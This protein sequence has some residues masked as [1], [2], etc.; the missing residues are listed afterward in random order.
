[1]Q[2]KTAKPKIVNIPAVVGK[3][4]AKWWH[5]KGRYRVVKGSRA[6]KKS[7]TASMWLVCYISATPGANALVVR[8]VASTLRDSVYAQIR[9]AIHN[10]ELDAYWQ[11]NVSPLEMTYTPT[12]QKILF[13]GCDDALKLS[14][15]TVP[16]GDLCHVLIEEAYEL[17]EEEFNLID[18][19]IRGELSSPSLYKQ[20][21]CIFNPWLATSWLKRRFFDREGD[22]DILAITT[23]YQCN[24]WLDEADR[25][26]F[27]RMAVESPQRFRV[28]GLGEWGVVG[29]SV[30]DSELLMARLEHIG[31]PVARGMFE[32]EA[33]GH[34]MDD[35][36]WREDRYGF[37]KIYERPRPGRPYVIGGD[38]AGA[39]SDSFV[40]QVIDNVTGCQVAM[41]RQ[42]FDE[43]L[44]AKQ[45]YCLG[46]M[47]N[48]ALVSIENNFST[49]PV[50]TLANL[51]YHNLWVRER[52]DTYTGKM[53]K[54]YGWLTTAG[55][56]NRIVGQLIEVVRETPE[57][58]ADRTTIEEMLTFVRGED[59]KPQA[60]E[61]AH[62]DTVMALCIAFASRDQQSYVDTDTAARVEWSDTQWEDYNNARSPRE[63]AVMEE[64]WGKPAARSARAVPQQPRVASGRRIQPLGMV[65][66]GRGRW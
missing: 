6:S 3:G 9:W 50:E 26:R 32:Y 15:I 61:G 16:V 37:I 4:Y 40:A 17:D 24:E 21:D 2:S 12:G 46:L 41:L 52:E 1:M 35:I 34:T 51:G 53:V 60:Q 19:A 27:E 8:K 38:T 62:D 47:Y 48:A 18:D 22:P 39:G 43:D 23:T 5:F 45:V 64:M 28:A 49:Y 29:D 65:S 13:R 20:I 63:R 66:G 7:T 31:E 10:L 57:I 11:C 33:N 25:R 14:S 58:L 42:Q 55:N 59:W 30:F 54:S 56:R 36:R 44:Y